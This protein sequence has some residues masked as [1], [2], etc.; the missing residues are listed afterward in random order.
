MA[1]YAVFIIVSDVGGLAIPLF[2]TLGTNALA[3]YAIHHAVETLEHQFVPKDSPAEVVAGALAVFFVITWM[4]I[5][6]LEKNKLY[7]RL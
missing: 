4:M 7:I 6:F 1:L 2:R 5:R 3:A